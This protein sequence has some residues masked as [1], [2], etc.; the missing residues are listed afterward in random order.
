MHA[1]RFA[2]T[3]RRAVAARCLLLLQLTLASAAWAGDE[4]LNEAPPPATPQ[5]VTTPLEESFEKA[6]PPTPNAIS[7]ALDKALEHL[8]PFLRD[9]Q[10]TL[11]LRTY[12]FDAEQPED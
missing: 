8:G 10:L 9:T 2:T 5:E 3:L 1:V 7:E 11:K 12:Y 4:A 6:A